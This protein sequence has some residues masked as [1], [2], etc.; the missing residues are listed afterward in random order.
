MKIGFFGLMM[1]VL[2]M[3]TSHFV[4]AQ[5]DDKPADAAAGAAKPADKPAAPPAPG[6]KVPADPITHTKGQDILELIQGGSKDVFIIVFFVNEK[7]GTD[8][9]TELTDK[10]VK[11][12]H[13]WIR[14]TTVDLKKVDTYND[15]FKTLKIEGEP[16]KLHSEPIVA[17]ISQ[18]EGIVIFGSDV[19][20]GIKSRLSKIEDKTL[21]QDS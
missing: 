16:K 8:T 7:T 11:D 17:V 13:E 1:I 19:A 20:G 5:T 14:T 12:G 15:L 2:M 4:R 10:V 18:G 21:Y 9:L 3:T 6:R